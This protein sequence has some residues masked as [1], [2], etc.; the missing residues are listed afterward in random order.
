[1]GFFSP[2]IK[3]T[4]KFSLSKSHFAVFS[5]LI[6]G[7]AIWKTLE[8]Q[9]GF[10]EAPCFLEMG[11]A[12]LS[13]ARKWGEARPCRTA[14]APWG[15]SP[16]KA[17]SKSSCSPPRKAGQKK[18]QH[19]AAIAAAG[20]IQPPPPKKSGRWVFVKAG[21]HR[22]G[23]THLN[24]RGVG[25]RTRPKKNQSA[26]GG[27]GVT[28]VK[29]ARTHKPGCKSKAGPENWFKANGKKTKIGPSMGPKSFF[30]GQDPPRGP[31]PL[32]ARPRRA[33]FLGWSVG[34]VPPSKPL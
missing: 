32:V 1:M 26:F 14:R 30:A 15:G 7:K 29:L 8:A 34:P 33:P 3:D 18:R 9:L 23:V 27:L 4:T 6:L 24:H 22:E 16:L 31:F 13:T 2:V 21:P 25:L 11:K 12:S 17:G 28:R 10:F 19:P 5:R 20:P